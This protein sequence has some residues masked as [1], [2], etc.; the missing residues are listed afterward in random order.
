MAELAL[1]DAERRYRSL[2]EQLP[3]ATYVLRFDPR[4]PSRVVPLYVGP[5]IQ[6]MLGVTSQ[7]WVGDPGLWAAMV[8]PDDLARV[9]RDGVAARGAGTPIEA[10]YRMRRRGG[11][12]VWI[13]DSSVPILDE[14][15]TAVA[16]QGIYQDVTERRRAEDVLRRQA[17]I[18]ESVHDAVVV[19]DSRG[20]VVDANLAAERLTGLSKLELLGGRADALVGADDTAALRRDISAGLAEE[21]RWSGVVAS[22][23]PDGSEGFLELEVVPL[24]DPRGVLLGSVAVSRDITEKRNSELALHASERR[25]RAVFD[26]AAV[27]IARLSLDGHVLEANDAVAELLGTGRRELLGVHLGTFLAEVG[28]GEVPEEFAR[29]ASGGLDRYEA[30]RDFVRR[31]GERIWCRVTASLVRDERGTAGLRDR[32]ARGHHGAEGGRGRAR[33]AG[34]ERRAH[35]A[36]EPR[37]AAR[38]PRHRA[39]AGRTRR[40]RRRRD[41]PG[42]GPVQAGQRRAGARGRRPRPARGGSPVRDLRPAR[43]HRRPLRRRRVR[44]ALPGRLERSRRRGGG[45]AA[46]EVSGRSARAAREHGGPRSASASA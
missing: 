25:F 28:P 32:D 43:R 13:H 44:G 5:Q 39:R 36:P 23:R 34:H 38:P 9:D 20:R 24:R 7:E 1:L 14:D 37:P 22:R 3:V 12:I 41:V 2:V 8:H 42:P 17:L 29:L 18:F 35:R 33:P 21:G 4:D 31:G 26:G 19:I 16:W 46:D 11:G 10:E 40:R 27:G 15:G 6:E 45:G 30:D